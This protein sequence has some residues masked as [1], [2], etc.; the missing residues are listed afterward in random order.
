MVA[1]DKTYM[2]TLGQLHLLLG[3]DLVLYSV[4]YY[5]CGHRELIAGYVCTIN[6]AFSDAFYVI[7]NGTGNM[8]FD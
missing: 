2:T 4:I 5:L 6:E 8:L 7:H 3:D 1:E